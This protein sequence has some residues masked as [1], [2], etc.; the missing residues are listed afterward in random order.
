MIEPSYSVT[1]VR[2]SAGV[3]SYYLG[4]MISGK[5]G[6]KQKEAANR[7]KLFPNQT[8]RGVRINISGEHLKTQRT[9]IMLLILEFLLNPVK[10]IGT[11]RLSIL[12]LKI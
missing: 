7:I 3:N 9:M 2:Q 5:G 1:H 12:L 10:H 8:K 11:I 4:I 6:P